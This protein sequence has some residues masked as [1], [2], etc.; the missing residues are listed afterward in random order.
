[1]IT[2][3]LSRWRYPDVWPENIR[4][5]W[6]WTRNFFHRGLYGW[7][8]DDAWDLNEYLADI[9]I[10]L[11]KELRK[12]EDSYPYK[13]PTLEEWQ[14]ILDTIREG[15]EAWQAIQSGE[16]ISEDNPQE[17]YNKL[18]QTQYKGFKKLAEYYNELWD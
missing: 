8:K 3:I 9:I 1:M 10:P 11:L 15:F 17:E 12:G 14:G 7:A 13:V 6:R 16:G 5:L 2:P 4:E 18:L